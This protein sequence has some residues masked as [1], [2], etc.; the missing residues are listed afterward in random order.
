MVKIILKKNEMG[1]NSLPYF[2]TLYN[3]VIKTVWYWQKDGHTE[4]QNRIGS[5]G[6]DPHKYVKLTFDKGRKAI[7]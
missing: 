3:Q 4:Q 7:Q 2:K 1:R 5:P 6:I